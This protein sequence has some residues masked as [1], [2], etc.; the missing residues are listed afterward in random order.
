[1]KYECRRRKKPKKPQTV[2]LRAN[3]NCSVKSNVRIW[4]LKLEGWDKNLRLE[5][6]SI[7]NSVKKNSQSTTTM[8]FLLVAIRLWHL[9]Y[10]YKPTAKLWELADLHLFS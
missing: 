2:D 8:R 10:N 5:L 9:V 1:M 4:E 6:H 3:E 7:L